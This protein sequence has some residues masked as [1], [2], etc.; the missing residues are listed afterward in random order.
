MVPIAVLV[1][2]D[3]AIVKFF[4]MHQCNKIYKALHL[5]VT[6]IP[7]IVMEKIMEDCILMDKFESTVFGSPVQIASNPLGKQKTSLNAD[8]SSASVSEQV[9]VNNPVTQDLQVVNYKSKIKLVY[10]NCKQNLSIYQKAQYACEK[11]CLEEIDSV[12]RG[13]NVLEFVWIRPALRTRIRLGVSV[14]AST[15]SGADDDQESRLSKATAFYRQT[16]AKDDYLSTLIPHLTWSRRDNL[17]FDVE[18]QLTHAMDYMLAATDQDA[19]G[20]ASEAFML[21]T[22]VIGKIE[23]QMVRGVQKTWKATLTGTD[24]LFPDN[25]LPG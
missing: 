6:N 9:Q 17:D 15:D 7:P 3:K 4:V 10:L 24:V 22:G 1:I 2:L 23:R 5:D 16:M 25:T 8:I 12:D 14:K 19:S 11:C 18:D 20:N 21:I 13:L